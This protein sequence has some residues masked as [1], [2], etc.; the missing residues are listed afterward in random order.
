MG[1]EGI[2]LY[3]GTLDD[4]RRV[5]IVETDGALAWF[6]DAASACLWIAGRQVLHR[7]LRN[8]FVEQG[9]EDGVDLRWFDDFAD[10][11]VP[12]LFIPYTA[13]A[14]ALERAHARFAADENV[15]PGGINWVTARSLREA[16]QPYVAREDPSD[17]GPTV[18]V[19]R[20]GEV[21]GAFPGDDP[22]TEA[23]TYIAARMVLTQSHGPVWV[24]PA[25]YPE[26]YLFVEFDGQYL[27]A[28]LMSLPSS[29]PQLG[30]G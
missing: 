4:E 14:P 21:L 18:M 28:D 26:P 7:Q 25:G 23:L 17:D 8:V 24:W 10:R 27:P 5:F 15:P 19:E 6:L 22:W 2:S 11:F 16:G 29:A 20:C 30:A 12:W 9:D 1:V 13:P 3:A